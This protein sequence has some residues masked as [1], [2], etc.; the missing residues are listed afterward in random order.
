VI[1]PSPRT[2][3]EGRDA[4]AWNVFVVFEQIFGVE[5]LNN[6][7]ARARFLSKQPYEIMYLIYTASH[8]E[9]SG[10][11][12]TVDRFSIVG[13]FSVSADIVFDES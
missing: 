2:R 8:I 10:A 7:L 4:R 12:C 3:G 13:E 11:V 5:Y 1:S 9:Y 6:G